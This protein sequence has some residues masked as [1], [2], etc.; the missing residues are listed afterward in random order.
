MLSTAGSRPTAGTRGS[1]PPPPVPYTRTH[2]RRLFQ[3]RGIMSAPA[4]PQSNALACCV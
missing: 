2:A 1:P 4:R 3:H